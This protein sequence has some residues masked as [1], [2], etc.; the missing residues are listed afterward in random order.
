M[1]KVNVEGVVSVGLS[2][3]QVV[4]LLLV[5]HNALFSVPIALSI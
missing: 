1:H 3:L 4:Q 5:D 2:V